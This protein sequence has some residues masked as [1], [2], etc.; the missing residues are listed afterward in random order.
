MAQQKPWTECQ[1]TTLLY[2]PELEH[3]L[4]A[5]II[6]EAHTTDRER[7]KGAV[8]PVREGIHVWH[9]EGRNPGGILNRMMIRLL[10]DKKRLRTQCWKCKEWF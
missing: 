5:Q 4:L 10:E 7:T 6:S 3:E 2:R 8:S 9:K 1:F